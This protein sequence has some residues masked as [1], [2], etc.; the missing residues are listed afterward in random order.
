M[1]VTA[2][3]TLHT[4]YHVGRVRVADASATKHITY[5]SKREKKP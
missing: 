1:S 2:V 4:R 5:G 3:R